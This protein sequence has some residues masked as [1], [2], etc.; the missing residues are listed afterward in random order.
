MVFFFFF[1]RRSQAYI[2]EL[3]LN[4]TR[5]TVLT[6]LAILSVSVHV[7]SVGVFYPMFIGMGTN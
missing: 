2:A 7:L 3:G 5:L 4:L 1:L 6:C